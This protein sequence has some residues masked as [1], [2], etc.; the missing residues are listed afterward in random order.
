METPP[1][2][3]ADRAVL[4]TGGGGG[5]GGAVARRLASEG[6]FVFVSGRN[7]VRCGAVVESIESSG[8][9]AVALE[10]DVA[11]PE[12]IAAA[13]DRAH[14][15]CPEGCTLDGL[16]NNA[17][18]ALSAPLLCA[19][20]QEGDVYTRHMAVNFHGARRLVE[21]LL[22][23]M[24]RSGYGRVVNI[25]SSAGLRGYPYVAAYCASK[26]ALVGYARAAACEL[27]DSGVTIASVCPHYVD[28]PLTEE[29]VRR[30]VEKTKKK[31]DE[32]RS[33]LAAENPGGRMVTVE[34]VADAVWSLWDGEGN[35]LIVEL[36]GGPEP[37]VHPPVGLRAL[38]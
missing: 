3:P 5:I 7:Q 16:V 29:T 22:P 35:G 36:D 12:S 34:E 26:H 24:K 11:S 17:G 25:A 23:E 31:E 32:V 38:R 8:G 18:I 10:L 1:A 2:T 9:R 4:V 27:E 20:D 6:L 15:L 33:F 28:S 30:I 37:I 13:L 21:K 19:D 14:E